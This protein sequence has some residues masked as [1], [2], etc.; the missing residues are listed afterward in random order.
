MTRSSANPGTSDLSR[1]Q[2]GPSRR[3]LIAGAAWSVPAIALVSSSPAFAASGASSLSLTTPAMRTVA[4]GTTPATAVVTGSDTKP[5]VG[6]PV[7]FTGPSGTSFSP[8]STTADAS[9]TATTT[10]TTTDDWATPGST[11]TITAVSG[12]VTTSAGLTVL[13]ANAYGYARYDNGQVNRGGTWYGTGAA[14]TGTEATTVTPP[15][16]LLKQFPS[17]IASV[18]VGTS[19]SLALL[20]NGTVWSVG[21]NDVGQLGDGTT[22][23]RVT[24]AQVPGL[25]GVT[26]I[27]AGSSTGYAL[28]PDGRILAWGYNNVG[29][30]GNGTTT[31]RPTPDL[32]ANI[33][34]ATQIVSGQVCAAALLAD[35]TVR[36]WGHNYYGQLG[37][38][39]RDNSSTPVTATGVTNISQLSAGP[40]TM[41]ALTKAGRIKSWGYGNEGALGDG[42]KTFMALSAVDVENIT[43]AVQVSGGDSRA[44]AVLSTGEVASWGSG[45]GYR[46][47][48]GTNTDRPSPVVLSGLSNVSRVIGGLNNSYALLNDGGI[49]SWGYDTRPSG[50]TAFSGTTGVTRIDT[51]AMGD[52][53]FFIR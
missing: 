47:G 36:T 44:H 23:D 14:G 13:G 51:S 38:G 52:Q 41:Y 11:L 4:A 19:F 40:V 21:R 30:L 49:R 48:D 22:T 27:A 43:N 24:W 34:T 3:T 37:N 17:P 33:T 26:Q 5:V 45:Y 20:K 2:S 6:A 1:E 50:P 39:T 28:R 32:V 12:G 8:A 29:Q 42:T 46:L 9:G 16:Q 25:A 10:L 7:S 18:A 15:T 35:S 53:T 31:N